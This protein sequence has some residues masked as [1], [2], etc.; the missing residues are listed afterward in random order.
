MTKRKV[1]ERGRILNEAW[2]EGREIT[3]EAITEII[4]QISNGKK[5]PEE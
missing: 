1:A 4:R 2:I 5:I 3:A